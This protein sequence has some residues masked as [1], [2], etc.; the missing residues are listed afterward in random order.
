MTRLALLL[1]LLLC[2]GCFRGSGIPWNVIDLELEAG[3]EA[4][5]RVEGGVSIGKVDAEFTFRGPAH[6][7]CERDRITKDGVPVEP[8]P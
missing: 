1:L 2:G 4:R 6:I 8:K 3:S 7:R 5:M